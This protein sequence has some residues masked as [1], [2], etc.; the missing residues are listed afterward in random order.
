MDTLD[1]SPKGLPAPTPD[2]R[3]WAL[4]RL[5]IEDQALCLRSEILR[6]AV[7]CDPAPRI[8]AGLTVYARRGGICRSIARLFVIAISGAGPTEKR[9]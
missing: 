2:R 4:P 1:I 8:K 5:V 7:L 3:F 9:H 6:L